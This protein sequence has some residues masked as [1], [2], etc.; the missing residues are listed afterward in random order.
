MAITIIIVHQ[1]GWQ[2]HSFIGWAIVIPS[3]VPHFFVGAT[4]GVFGNEYGGVWGAIFGP[5]LNGILMT[6][7]PILIFWFKI[8]AYINK[9]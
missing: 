2:D 6:F 5:F 8:Y 3:I 4:A 9:C 1:I 7:I